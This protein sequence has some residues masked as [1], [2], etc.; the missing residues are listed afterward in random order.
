MRPGRPAP[1]LDEPGRLALDR[2][3]CRPALLAFD[4]DGTLAPI[5]DDPNAAVASKRVARAAARLC[6]LA[7][8]A[9][10]TGR[11]LADIGARLSFTPRHLVGNH[12]MEGLPGID[13]ARHAAET[14]EAQATCRRWIAQLRA[15]PL[16]DGVQVEDKALSLSVHWRAAP[17]Q[18]AAVA[19]VEAALDRLEPPPRRIAGKCV[20][21]L[22]PAGA[23]TKR[24]AIERLLAHE[25]LDAVLFVGDDHTDEIA[26]EQAPANWLTV[27]IGPFERTAARFALDDQSEIA[28]LLEL[29]VRRL[30][31]CPAA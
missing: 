9:V 5:V 20:V 30:E 21:N 10:I 7:P 2:L 12:G 19:S 18:E 3:L 16:A 8:V 23:H 13:P 25:R 11:S 31:R 26:F 4:F 14:A 29:V 22:L 1:L 15:A 27:R 28:A 17:D 24:D 6:V